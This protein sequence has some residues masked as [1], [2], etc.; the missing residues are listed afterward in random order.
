MTIFGHRSDIL[1]PIRLTN[2]ESKGSNTS[3]LNRSSAHISSFEKRKWRGVEQTTISRTEIDD[4]IHT[5]SI[6]EFQ[7]LNR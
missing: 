5:F 3:A 2:C 7:N 6:R 1:R 4:D